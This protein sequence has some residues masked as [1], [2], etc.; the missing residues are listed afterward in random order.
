MEEGKGFLDDVTRLASE[1][2]TTI[3]RAG[4]KA[5]DRFDT[6]RLEQ[7][8]NALLSSFGQLVYKL[9]DNGSSGSAQNDGITRRINQDQISTNPEVLA[10][11][12]KIRN[13][14]EEIAIRKASKVVSGEL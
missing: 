10:L 9:M 8:A 4:G 14:K 11:Y 5:L 1:A 13:L 3:V 6:W 12:E 2:G 7:D